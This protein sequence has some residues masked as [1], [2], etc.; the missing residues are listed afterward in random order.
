MAVFDCFSA[1]SWQM[2]NVVVAWVWL[3]TGTSRRQDG[4]ARTCCGLIL[5][6]CKALKLFGHGFCV[7]FFAASK[8]SE[9]FLPV[10]NMFWM[11]RC[12][13]SQNWKQVELPGIST[14]GAQGEMFKKCW[15]Q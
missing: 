14:L 10:A 1:E 3:C 4:T 2:I 12:Q 15:Q 6:S 8:G 9:E 13:F 11:S 5:C 7:S